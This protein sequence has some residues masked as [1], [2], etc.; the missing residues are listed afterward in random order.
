[1]KRALMIAVEVALPH[2]FAL[3]VG[4]NVYLGTGKNWHLAWAAGLAVQAVAATLREIRDGER[5]PWEG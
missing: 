4:V 1:M 5:R 2:F 3:M